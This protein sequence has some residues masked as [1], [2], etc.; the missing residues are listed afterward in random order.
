M[1]VTNEVRCPGCGR[2]TSTITTTGSR[3]TRCPK[4]G[5][6]LKSVPETTGD[7]PKL[8]SAQD[9]FRED[10]QKA[11]PAKVVDKEVKAEKLPSSQE[12]K[13]PAAAVSVPETPKKADAPLEKVF[14]PSR[15][16]PEPPEVKKTEPVSRQPRVNKAEPVSKLQPTPPAPPAPQKM[17]AS[18]DPVAPEPPIVSPPKGEPPPMRANAGRSLDKLERFATEVLAD[19]PG[20]EL[21]M[22]EEPPVVAEPEEGEAAVAEQDLSALAAEYAAEEE[23][24]TETL[25]ADLSR[26]VAQIDKL[27]G[28]GYASQHP[29][30]ITAALQA[31]QATPTSADLVRRLEGLEE[32]LARLEALLK[33]GR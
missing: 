14:S 18:A 7:A 4:C 30:L 32:R 33:E 2:K 12:V 10:I 26:I 25:S 15:R 23:L 6:T 1:A 31:Q 9:F 24:V 28:P 29:Q 8:E 16:A 20:G 27:F 11:E 19:Q 21:E 3:V 17:E 13:S 5:A 22:A